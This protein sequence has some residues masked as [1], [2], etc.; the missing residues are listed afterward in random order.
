MRAKREVSFYYFIFRRKCRLSLGQRHSSMLQ[1][2][3]V[4]NYSH[5][6]C[7]RGDTAVAP[8]VHRKGHAKA[9]A[10][11]AVSMPAH[12]GGM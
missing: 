8:L 2:Q 12:G 1:M 7:F 11:V 5:D 3:P 10:R 4:S 6:M 9:V